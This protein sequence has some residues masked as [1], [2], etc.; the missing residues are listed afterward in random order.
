MEQWIVFA[1]SITAVVVIVGYLAF[2]LAGIVFAYMTWC[3]CRHFVGM[4]V[5][6]REFLKEIFPYPGGREKYKE[7][8]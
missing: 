6:F 7:E 8:D 1:S 3:M 2:H 5:S 4:D